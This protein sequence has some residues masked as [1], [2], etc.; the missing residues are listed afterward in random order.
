MISRRPHHF[1]YALAV[2]LTCSFAEVAYPADIDRI[3]SVGGAVTE[4]LYA[5]GAD[6]NIVGVDSTSLYPARASAEK[7]NVG[8]MRQL[9]A[10]GVLGLRPSLIIAS[11]GSGPKETMDVLR[12]AHVPIVTVPDVFS[13]EGIVEKVRAV[14][15]AANA[16]ERGQCVTAAV[17]A[18]LDALAALRGKVTKPKR[19]LFVLSLVNGRAMA[20]GGKT[21]ADGIIAMAGAVNAVT[22]YDGYKALTD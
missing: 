8:Y 10:E 15:Q 11:E 3:V 21:A 4:I 1:S 2:A 7:P 14:A 18:D 6:K 22:D 5:L 19:V 9:S 13:G 16:T 20:G 12:A 17:R